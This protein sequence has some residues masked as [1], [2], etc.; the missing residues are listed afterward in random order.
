MSKIRSK[1]ADITPHS[2]YIPKLHRNLL[3]LGKQRVDQLDVLRLGVGLR[4]ALQFVPGL[5]FVL[6]L[7]VKHARFGRRVVASSRLLVQAIQA[8][9][10]VVRRALGQGVYGFS[11]LVLVYAPRPRNC[12]HTPDWYTK[13]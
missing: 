11:L 3:I 12:R 4:S 8:Q 7:Q 6:P 1:G 2:P 5:P 9:Q 10:L 13:I